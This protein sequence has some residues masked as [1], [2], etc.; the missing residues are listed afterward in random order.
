MLLGSS[1]FNTLDIENGINKYS[2]T[3]AL[4]KMYTEKTGKKSNIHKYNVLKW[5]EPSNTIP[6]HLKKDGLRHIHPDYLQARSITV[7]EA[8]RLQ[9]FDDDFEFS[10]MMTADYEMIGNAVPPEFARRLAEC[11]YEF[12][13]KSMTY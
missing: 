3:D 10:G 12:Y 8:A 4:K 2:S 13:K 7:R 1:H 6:A 5:D 11:I 9:S